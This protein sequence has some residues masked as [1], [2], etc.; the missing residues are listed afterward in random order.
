MK[1]YDKYLREYEKADL[2]FSNQIADREQKA[3]EY[4]TIVVRNA[5]LI[6]GG[7]L[8]AIPAIAGLSRDIPVKLSEAATAG[9]LFASALIVSILGSY[10]IHINW[11]LHVQAW[12]SFWEDRR[13]YLERTYLS[14]EP[15]EP[16]EIVPMLHLQKSITLT[17]YLPHACAIAYLVLI[18]LG[19]TKLYGAFGIT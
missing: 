12:E 2:Y 15:I 1:D 4:G 5:V 9:F 13:K 18:I 11:T 3:F 19:F 8:L 14:D 17:F 6:S 7:A 16:S 10:I